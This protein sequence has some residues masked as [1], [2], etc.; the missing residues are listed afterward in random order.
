MRPTRMAKIAIAMGLVG[1]ICV[2]ASGVTW[3]SSWSKCLD[4]LD[5]NGM[6]VDRSQIIRLTRSEEKLWGM[7]HVVARIMPKGELGD[8]YHLIV[9]K[10]PWG[11]ALFLVDTANWTRSS[12]ADETKLYRIGRYV[13]ALSKVRDR[14]DALV[15]FDTDGEP[16]ELTRSWSLLSRAQNAITNWQETGQVRGIGRFRFAID[17]PANEVRVVRAGSKFILQADASTMTIDPAH[18]EAENSVEGIA[19]SPPTKA[20]PGLITWVVDSV[21][22]ISWIGPRPIEWLEHHFFG[23][24]D[25]ITRFYHK[26]IK[27]SEASTFA[28]Q[29]SG[30]RSAVA[31]TENTRLGSATS[32]SKVSE[33]LIARDFP[34]PKLVSPLG[35]NVQGEGEWVAVDDPH[36]VNQYPNAPTAFYQTFLRVDAERA[37][38]PIYITVWD[39]RLVQLHIVMGTKEP[40]S[41]TG[42]TGT[43]EVPKT[44]EV[45]RHFVAAFNGGFQALH[46]EFGMMADRRVYLPPKPWAATIAV[47]DSGKVGMGSWPAPNNRKGFDEEQANAQIPKDMIAMRQNLTSVVESGEYNPWKRWWWGAAPLNAKEQTFTHRTG[48]CLTQ[49]G[50]M[51]FFWGTLLGPEALGAGMLAMKCVRGMHLDMNSGHCGFEFYATFS[52]HSPMPPLG[53]A[54]TE[55]YEAEG[56]WRLSDHSVY[57]YRTRKAVT[58]MENM[59]FPRYNARD[60]RDFFYLTLKP[61]LPGPPLQIN[62][63]TVAFEVDDL[64][65]KAFPPAAALAKI[66]KSAVIKFDPRRTQKVPFENVQSAMRVLAWQRPNPSNSVQQAKDD[67]GFEV[68]ASGDVLKNIGLTTTNS[69]PSTLYLEINNSEGKP[70][71]TTLQGEVV[72]WKPSKGD[73]A[74]IESDEKPTE[75]IFADTQ[76][77]PYGVWGWLQNQRVRYI[78]QSAPRFRAPGLDSNATPPP[79]NN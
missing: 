2:S 43:G 10:L 42:E 68:F 59:R 25:A 6:R 52:E 53:R 67:D 32:E 55:A 20:E 9:W 7:I 65:V 63:K 17:P 3:H 51:A 5:R 30:N 41:A 71:Y 58:E 29:L 38:A 64:N 70:Q 8:V 76:P 4:K 47:F 57:R 28:D 27:N 1:F 45:I 11:D 75:V 37:F 16:N 22:K 74:W 39:P 54:L 62:G 15:V 48:L 31:K 72:Q 50:Q 18:P 24:Q 34:P 69:T 77:V 40:E 66:D 61:V 19:L 56:A 79:G 35:K 36:F 14:Y 33:A 73:T 23:I 26:W 13:A 78:P 49:N 12:L 60:A 46:G 21:R 44:P